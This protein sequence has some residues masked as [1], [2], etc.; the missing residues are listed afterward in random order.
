MPL[1]LNDNVIV[2]RFCVF[3]YLSLYQSTTYP[4]MH[5]FKQ[6][7]HKRPFSRT[8]SYNYVAMDSHR[9]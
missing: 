2:I 5:V 9:E 7:R 1:R 8:I 6:A 4:G 3:H